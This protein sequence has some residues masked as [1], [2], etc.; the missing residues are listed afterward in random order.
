MR[1]DE[2]TEI[3]TSALN[4]MTSPTELKVLICSLDKLLRTKD[5]FDLHTERFNPTF[6]FQDANG[7][8]Y[9]VALQSGVN[10]SIFEAAKNL[11]EKH[12][13]EDDDE[14]NTGL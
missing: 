7:I 8:E 10:H 12:F 13:P 6:I 9:C 4:S 5:A 2:T 14:L 11:L 1:R 3:L